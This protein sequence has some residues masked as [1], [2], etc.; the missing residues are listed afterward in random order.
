MSDLMRMYAHTTV[1]DGQ[2]YSCH[3][4][5][6][7]RAWQFKP[8]LHVDCCD[9]T[10]VH[11]GVLKQE[12]NGVRS[13]LGAGMTTLVRPGDTHRL[14]GTNLVM[15]TLNFRAQ[16]LRLA[17]SFL[18]LEPQA[19]RLLTG[20]DA[21]LLETPV[22]A[23]SARL[24]ELEQL[25]FGQRDP[26]AGRFFRGFLVR[27]L[28]TVEG[29]SATRPGD[30][31]PAWL[32]DLVTFIEDNVELPVTVTD[33][34]R[35]AGRSAEHI[36]RSFRTHLAMTPSTAINRARLDR[37]AL[38]LAH[39]NRSILDICYSLG[40]NSPSYFYRLFRRVHGVPPRKY[41][42]EQSVLVGARERVT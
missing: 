41:R 26:H 19:E 40:Y 5:D 8:H 27:W 9:L 10:Y 21:P 18:G 25:L 7:N 6:E 35:R 1:G 38:L 20:P 31:T 11:H 32:A 2:E 24:I 34:A 39:T 33:L 37:A 4:V 23:R 15:Y 13:V 36:A 22:S 42:R 17:A 3:T 14:W 28:L 16:S 12:V 29:E 30:R